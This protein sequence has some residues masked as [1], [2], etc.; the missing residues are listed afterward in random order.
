M[1]NINIRKANINDTNII[2]GFIKQ[3]AEYEKLGHEVV[4]DAEQLRETLFCKNSVAHVLIGE[5]NGEAC[6]F[7]LY[8]YN[9]STFQA[10]PGIYLEDLFV[11]DISRGSGLGKALLLKLAKIAIE[12]NCGRLEWSVLNWNKPTIDFY[13]SIGATPIEGWTKYRLDEETME[14]I[15]G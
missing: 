8:F 3:L 10:K 4:A 13:L 7:A 15:G 6:G 14:N 9:Y 12:N 11:N 1:I 5:I 2:L